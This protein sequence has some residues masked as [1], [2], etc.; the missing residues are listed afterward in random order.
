MILG[1][2]I[3]AISDVTPR[4][5]SRAEIISVLM[6]SFCSLQF[7]KREL[8]ILVGI[9]ASELLVQ[10]GHVTAF[11]IAGVFLGAYPRVSGIVA[12][13]TPSCRAGMDGLFMESPEE[14]TGGLS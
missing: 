14:T 2:S 3:C 10:S 6:I 13:E 7:F 9:P 11:R 5:E 12:R 1:L 4:M 8:P